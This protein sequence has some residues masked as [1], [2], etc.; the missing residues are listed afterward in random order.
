[1]CRTVLKKEQKLVAETS[2]FLV[3]EQGGFQYKWQIERD[4]CWRG[5]SV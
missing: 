2:Y 5:G 3:T 4:S 1:M